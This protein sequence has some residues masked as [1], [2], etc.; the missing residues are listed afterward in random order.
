[1]AHTRKE[2]DALNT[3]KSKEMHLP[4]KDG[5]LFHSN[6][7]TCPSSKCILH[8]IPEKPSQSSYLKSFMF[9]SSSD[10]DNNQSSVTP[11][12]ITT[13]HPFNCDSHPTHPAKRRRTTSSGSNSDNGD[14]Q[15]SGAAITPRH[16]SESA[17]SGTVC[18]TF[19]NKPDR[20]CY[21]PKFPSDDLEDLKETVKSTPPPGKFL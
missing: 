4:R 7:C 3:V 1:M 11:R 5:K 19:G 8:P 10:D 14:K 9:D 20:S 16:T 17:K 6:S 2:G 18:G 12:Q 13:K 15:R 21:R